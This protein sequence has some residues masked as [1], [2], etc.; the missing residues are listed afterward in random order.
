MKLSHLLIALALLGCSNLQ[1][2][3]MD[4]I[5]EQYN[6]PGMPGAAVM[7]IKDGNVLFSHGYGLANVE[8]KIPVTDSTD[9]RLASVTK[10]FTAMCILQ[11]I[12]KGK[13]DFQTKL[14]SIFPQLP[15]FANKITIKNLLQH[16]AGLQDY[17]SLI[18][19][20]ATVQVKDKDVLE[21]IA[22][23]DSL[24]FPPGTKHKYSNTG[25]AI[26]SLV[27]EKISG[28]PFRDYLKKNIFDPLKMK[29]TLAYEKGINTIPNRA[30]GYTVKKDTV[31]RAA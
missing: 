28:M 24:Y 16:A 23:T 20:T 14:K 30:F 1:V 7:V 25:Y 6:K 15:D 8:E 13:L 31:I 12:E 5:F 11:L 27:V 17:E 10:Q 4:K 29:K 19:D 18:P 26:L 21:M 2:N 3:K 9:F 22:K